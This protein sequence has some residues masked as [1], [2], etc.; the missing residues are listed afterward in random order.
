MYSYK[1]VGIYFTYLPRSPP[2][3]RFT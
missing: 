1:N 3:C 2:L